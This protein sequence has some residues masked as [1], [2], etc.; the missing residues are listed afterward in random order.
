MK[1]QWID[2][3]KKQPDDMQNV[4][5]VTTINSEVLVGFFE[6]PDKHCEGFLGTFWTGNVYGVISKKDGLYHFARGIG[7]NVWKHNEHE[8]TRWMPLEMPKFSAKTRKNGK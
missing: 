7:F 1:Q 5:F 6:K 8:V 4:Y 2:V 3:R